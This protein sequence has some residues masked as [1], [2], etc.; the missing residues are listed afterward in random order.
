MLPL[1]VDKPEAGEEGV[2]LASPEHSSAPFATSCTP[3]VL[4]TESFEDVKSAW[5]ASVCSSLRACWTEPA[6]S[7]LAIDASEDADED[8][9]WR[10]EWWWW[11]GG[12]RGQASRENIQHRE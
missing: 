7:V 8:I 11:S 10:S 1:A 5:L 2:G 9:V 6:A 4:E 3:C 12:N